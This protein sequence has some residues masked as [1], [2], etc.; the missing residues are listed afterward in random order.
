MH[1]DGVPVAVINTDDHTGNKAALGAIAAPKPTYST[2][3]V[4]LHG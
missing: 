2:N 3:V 4:P 1:L